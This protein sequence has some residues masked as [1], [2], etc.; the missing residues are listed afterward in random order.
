MREYVLQAVS[1]A[2]LRACRGEGAR[3]EERE[4]KD[5]DPH[6]EFTTAED[7]TSLNYMLSKI[8]DFEFTIFIIRST[9][10][11]V[12]KREGRKGRGR[13]G[14]GRKGGG[15]RPRADSVERDAEEAR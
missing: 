15:K 6:L 5:K 2:R 11:R 1:L 14:G 7:G 13:K 10:D 9:E 12:G 8:G 4:R 3:E